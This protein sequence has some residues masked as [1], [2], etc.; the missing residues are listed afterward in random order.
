[1]N[2]THEFFFQGEVKYRK[3]QLKFG[4]E[5]NSLTSDL[6]KIKNK[7]HEL[8]ESLKEECLIPE[9][10]FSI[11]GIRKHIQSVFNE[12]RRARKCEKINYD[13]VRQFLLLVHSKTIF[14]MVKVLIIFVAMT[15]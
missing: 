12:R 5:I 2:Y 7:L 14:T 1:M 4:Q 9:I 3:P 6:L 13:L 15:S 8:A 11:E 10:N